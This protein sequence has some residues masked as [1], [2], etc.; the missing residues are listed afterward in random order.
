MQSHVARIKGK[1]HEAIVLMSILDTVL[2]IIGAFL[3]L[4]TC[5]NIKLYLVKHSIIG[6]IIDVRHSVLGQF[7][8]EFFGVQWSTCTLHTRDV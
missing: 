7:T 8:D 4:H 3:S 6:N 1:T 2:A 5:A